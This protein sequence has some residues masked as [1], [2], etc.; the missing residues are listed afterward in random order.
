AEA[1]GKYEEMVAAGCFQPNPTGTSY[2]T[3]NDRVAK[4][5]SFG[6]FFLGT[7]LAALQALAPETNFRIHAFDSGDDP[8]HDVVALSTQGGAAINAKAKNA[9]A[10]ADFVS[11]LAENLDIY[12]AAHP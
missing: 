12:V 3:A 11:F 1:F 5:E 8:E 7:R 10:A 9:T 2:E 4:G 6:E